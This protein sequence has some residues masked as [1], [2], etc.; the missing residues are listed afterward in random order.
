[1]SGGFWASVKRLLLFLFDAFARAIG[2]RE[3][4]VVS[5]QTKG[6]VTTPDRRMLELYKKLADEEG[7]SLREF[8][9]KYKLGRE[10]K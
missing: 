2:V 6:L 10:R 9:L 1:M 7:L 5:E 3:G 4:D 8:L